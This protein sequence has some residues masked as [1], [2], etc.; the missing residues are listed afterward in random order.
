MRGLAFAALFATTALTWGNAQSQTPAIPQPN[1]GAGPANICQELI[2]FLRE[3][4]ST[5]SSAGA[6]VPTQQTAV[7]APQE[8]KGGAA[9]VQPSGQG[10][11]TSSGL[12]GPIPSTSPGDASARH[13]PGQNPAS[14]EASQRDA[15]QTSHLSRA[16][17]DR[18]EASA[19]A[20]D[21]AG[22]RGAAQEMRRAGVPLPP[23]LIALAGL[24]LKHLQPNP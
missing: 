19:R 16:L 1:A 5:M 20:N 17:V 10:A 12:S 9:P 24:Q 14:L 11:P 7:A 21:I 2:T 3:R 6:R 18:A 4:Q 15:P 8:G 23:S 13:A 22:C